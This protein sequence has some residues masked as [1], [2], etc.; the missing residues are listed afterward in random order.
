MFGIGGCEEVKTK[1]FR[2]FGA[3]TRKARA[4]NKLEPTRR[5]SWKLVR[6]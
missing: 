2:I 5:T 1:E 6:N 4:S 3:A